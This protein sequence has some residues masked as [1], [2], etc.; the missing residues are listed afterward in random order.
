MNKK[1]KSILFG[2]SALLLASIFVLSF[3]IAPAGPPPSPSIVSNIIHNGTD[4]FYYDGEDVYFNHI[5]VMWGIPN[6]VGN[7]TVNCSAFGSP[8]II[9]PARNETPIM[10][11]GNVTNYTARCPVNYSNIPSNLNPHGGPFTAIVGGNITFVAINSSGDMSQPGVLQGVVL[12]YNFTIPQM[13]PG[14]PVRFGP[15]MTNMADEDDFSDV[16]YIIDIQINGSDVGAPWSGFQT[17]ALYDFA[18][19]NMTDQ[20]IPNELPRLAPPSGISV[21]IN[22]SSLGTSHIFLNSTLLSSFNTAAT[23]TLFHLPFLTLPNVTT[24]G[25]GAATSLSYV[26]GGGS[27]N[28]TFNVDHFSTY[29]VLDN[30]VPRINMTSPL[31]NSVKTSSTVLLNITL[32]GTASAIDQ[33]QSYV[34]ITGPVPS[35]FFVSIM[36]CSNLSDDTIRCISS[37]SG[38]SNGQYNISI[39]ARD[40]GN[41]SGNIATYNG[42]FNVSIAVA[43]NCGDT[44]TASTT[45]NESLNCSSGYDFPDG[46]IIGE[47][48]IILDCNG[49]TIDGNGRPA[50]HGISNNGFD[51]VTIKN[52]RVTGFRTAG[53]YFENGADYGTLKNNIATSN[54]GDGF[55]LYLN[56]NNNTLINNTAT[57]N[58]YYGFF[59]VSNSNNNTLINNTATSNVDG[60]RI[61]EGSGNTFINN[62]ATLNTN[63]GFYLQFSSNNTL[64][65][66]RGCSNT[67]TDLYEDTSPSNNSW[68]SSTYTNSDPTDITYFS[69]LH[70]CSY[71]PLVVTIVY[72]ASDGQ[73]LSGNLTINYTLSGSAAQT[74]WYSNGTGN[75]TITCG[76]NITQTWALGSHT[77]IIYANESTGSIR[78]AT[79]T[80]NINAPAQPTVNLGTAN[81]FAILAGSAITG[82]GA[83]IVIGDVGLDPTGGAAITALKCAEMTGVIYDNDGLYVGGGSPDVTCR[84]TNATLII[85][86][87]NDILTAY[88]DAANRTPI[89]PIVA[90]LG[91]QTLTPGVYNSATSIGLTGTLTLDAQGNSSAVFVFQ[92]GSTLT[93]AGN[94]SLINGA[95]ASNVFWQVGSSATFG[96]GSH[97]KGTIIALT[98]IDLNA[99]GSVEGRLLAINGAVTILT[100]TTVTSPVSGTDIIAP[101]ATL[102]T[103]GNGNFTNG[104]SNLT[105]N[106]SDNAGIRNA[107][108]NVYNSTG[109]YNRTTISLGGVTNA[110]VGVVVYLVEGVYTWFWEVFD[111]AGNYAVSGNNTVTVDAMKPSLVLN[112][113]ADGLVTNNNNVV[114]NFTATDSNLKNCSIY[115][116]G[117]YLDTISGGSLNNGTPS[118]YTFLGESEGMH[119]WRVTC[120]DL[121]G[122]SNASATS[123]YTIDT[124]VPSLVQINYPLNNSYSNSAGGIYLN[125][126]VI[127]NLATNLSC[128]RNIDGS[129]VQLYA[130]NGTITSIGLALSDGLHTINYINCSDNAGNSNITSSP[131]LFTQDTIKPELVLNWPADGLVTNNNNIVFNITASDSNLD[132]CTRYSD[133]FYAGIFPSL[134]NGTPTTY[135]SLGVGDG[136]YNWSVTCFDLASN[137]N[138]SATRTYTIDTTGPTVTA[139]TPVSGIYT[140]TRNNTLTFNVTDNIATSFNCSLIIAGHINSTSLFSSGV[141]SLVYDFVT[142]GA[143]TWYLNC[144]D[145]A[146]NSGI[147][148]PRSINVDITK[149]TVA[150][151]DALTETSGVNKSR[152]WIF[153][154]SIANDTNFAN[155]TFRLYNSAGVLNASLTNSTSGTGTVN[156]TGL[157]DGVYYY[158]LTACDLA[159]NC[160]STS[161]RKISLDNAAPVLSV[162]SSATQTSLTLT[163]S[164][165]TDTTGLN[166]TCTVDRNATVNGLAINESGLS[167]G[168]SYT[169]NITCYD[170]LGLL[171]NITKSFSTSSCSSGDGGGSSGGGSGNGAVDN[172]SL[173]DGTTRTLYTGG[174]LRFN[175]AGVSHTLLIMKIYPNGVLIRIASTPQLANISSGETKEFDV[176]GDGENDIS[177]KLNSVTDGKSVSITL[178]AISPEAAVTEPVV[179]VTEEKKETVTEKVSEAI[180]KTPTPVWIIVLVV[181]VA[182]VIVFSLIILARRKAAIAQIKN[183]R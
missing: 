7:L 123:S 5:G 48:N 102:L 183:K 124:I 146:G 36:T 15:L 166:G 172:S 161:T 86:A 8:D 107:T 145:S 52:C 109:L 144:S 33:A 115:K 51:N 41:N 2:I 22:T 89:S 150:F 19:L 29:N 47:N 171:G 114:V 134:N 101:N 180:K 148:N 4:N 118:T 106:I 178:Q 167:C 26:Y 75:T 24:D 53:I 77:L 182:I 45:L 127:D 85:A 78:S 137:L 129:P 157:S 119:T 50:P 40:T 65:S 6:S 128:M 57:S 160:N 17:V 55:Y 104:F 156:W 60:F 168:V 147:S 88:N 64:T 105:A 98:S 100:G 49:F 149:P 130:L 177:V 108:L 179:P 80:F 143:P 54:Q 23:L 12:A 16:N 132:N 142:E 46:L 151:N 81:H 136:F 35:S 113:P 27:G 103:P 170:Y 31:N 73:N 122:N 112:G 135:S 74:C 165:P 169:Y 9:P 155:V 131:I 91:G 43:V 121:A 120:Y 164:A 117:S 67:V 69:Q 141:H 72:P 39:T 37:L 133:G 138:V 21:N 87:K 181:I 66:N 125:F 84:L 99:G 126:T 18:S 11:F 25:S 58:T 111:I 28:L 154:K 70:D 139:I 1:A 97:I 32:N 71:T 110:V 56:S 13:P 158:N 163:V 42:R 83:N 20:A 14:Q 176:N 94:V 173:T 79:R 44:I 76:T 61:S 38:L 34:N 68:S 96:T 159:N 3:I 59:V 93:T 175:V 10:Y 62:I 152:N 63:A 116:E 95:N 162:G 92:A 30:S 140:N 90:D 174:V 153:A 82:T